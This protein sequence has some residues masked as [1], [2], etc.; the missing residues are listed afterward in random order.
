MFTK[1]LNTHYIYGKTDTRVVH[2]RPE[3]CALQAGGAE[4][5]SVTEA[6]PHELKLGEGAQSDEGWLSTGR[7]RRGVFVRRHLR[8]QHRRLGVF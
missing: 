8:N 5:H 6:A 4:Q 2:R 7:W 1:C 3:L